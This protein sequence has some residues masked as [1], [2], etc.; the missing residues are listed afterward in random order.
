MLQNVCVTKG[1]RKRNNRACCCCKIL[2]HNTWASLESFESLKIIPKSFDGT[3]NSFIVQLPLLLF[4]LFLFALFDVLVLIGRLFGLI[5][6][7]LFSFLGHFSLFLRF[8]L[9]WRFSSGLHLLFLWLFIL[10]L[11]FLRFLRW[12]FFGF[13]F[14]RLLNGALAFRQFVPFGRGLIVRFTCVQNEVN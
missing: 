6:S 3:L 8:L 14:H 1:G 10:F 2:L 12:C 7:W 11:F 9:G 13:L 5:S 4:L